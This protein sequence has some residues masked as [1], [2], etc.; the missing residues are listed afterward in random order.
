MKA[1]I[2]SFATDIYPT[3]EEVKTL[4]K[5]GQGADT[6]VWLLMAPTG[7][8]CSCLNKPISLLE[9]SRRGETVAKRDGC[10]KVKN[11]HPMGMELGEVE[12]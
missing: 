12:F 8:E 5:P 9:R 2:G 11:F 6:C 4:C 7:W 1:I 3:D 10:D